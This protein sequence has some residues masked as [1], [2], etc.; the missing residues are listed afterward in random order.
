MAT[1]GP[2]S[3]WDPAHS[4]VDRIPDLPSKFLDWLLSDPKDPPTVKE[5]AVENDVN[6]RQTRIWKQDPRFKAEWE[7]RA[8]ELN[9]GVERV[10]EVLERLRQVF[11]DT[12]DVTAAKLWLDRVDRVRPPKKVEEEDSEFADLSDEALVAA[13]RDELGG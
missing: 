8:N 11:L 9:V 3:R 6:E 12:G 4:G 10:Q 1:K 2:E 7:R 13:L 5:W